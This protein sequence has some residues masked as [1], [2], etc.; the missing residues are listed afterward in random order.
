M[1]KKY[2]PFSNSDVP[3]IYLFKYGIGKWGVGGSSITDFCWQGGT[4]LGCPTQP[5][6]VFAKWTIFI[7]NNGFAGRVG[8]K[9]NLFRLVCLYTFSKNTILTLLNIRNFNK[10]PVLI[11]HMTML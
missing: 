1:S 10:P 6:K 9:K 8:R 2:V 4:G 3:S 7:Q 5:S 11:L